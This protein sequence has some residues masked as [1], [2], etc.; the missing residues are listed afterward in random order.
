MAITNRIF[1]V[2]PHRFGYNPQTAVNNVFQQEGADQDEVNQQALKEFDGFVEALRSYGIDVTVFQDD[3][4]A[5]TPDSIFPNNWISMHRDGMVA[6]YPM[7]AEN[8]R[9]E[10]RPQIINA[11]RK[12]FTINKIMDFTH[13]EKEGKFLEGTGSV[14]IDRNHNLAFACLSERTNM[15]I[16]QDYERKTGYK[17]IPFHAV[18]Q[19]GRPIYHTNVMM[20]LGQRYVVIC[21]DSIHN[22]VE[23][24]MLIEVFDASNKKMIPITYK[25]MNRYAGNMMQLKNNKDE[26]VLVMSTQAYNSLT[27]EQVATL[28]SFNPILHFPLDTIEA[29][30]GGSARCMLAEI[31]LPERKR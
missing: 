19:N 7:F 21:M 22:Q 16:L 27:P 4:K 23:R 6:L 25:Q 30:G 3:G 20:C 14:V 26:P 12:N 29:N 8:R 31:F 24:N 10:R 18:D 17:V 1:M 13:Y 5:E 15:E 2:R 9:R 28:E 11:L